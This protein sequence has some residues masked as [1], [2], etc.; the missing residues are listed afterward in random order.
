MNIKDYL[1]YSLFLGAIMTTFSC[2]DFLEEKS[3]ETDYNYYSTPEGFESAVVGSYQ[4]LRWL[5]TGEGGHRFELMGTDMYMRG[6]DGSQ[7]ACYGAYLAG[8]MSPSNGT[9]SDLWNNNYNGIA[10]VNTALEAV[11]SVQGIDESILKHRRGELLFLRAYYYY[12]LVI[13]YGDIPL[14]L[15][16][17]NSPKTDYVRVPQKEIWA[18]II[19]DATEAWNLLSWADAEG[20]VQGDYGRIG[21]GAAGHL[22]T[23]AHLFRYGQKYTSNQS[24]SHMNEDRGTESDDLDK[25]IYYS[26]Q[27][28]NFG[29][30][31]GSGSNH[32]LE[33][34]FWNLWGWDDKLGL[35]KEYAGPEVVFSI[36][37]ST[38]QFYNNQTATSTSGGNQI[39][40][41]CSAQFEAYPL[42]T[43]G[44]GDSW[45]NS[46]GLTRDYLTGRPWKRYAPTPYL[47]QDN[48]VY[49][50]QAYTCH[51]PGKLIDSRLYKAHV[52]TYYANVD[53]D[54]PWKSYSNAAGSFDAG[55]LEGTQRFAKG[56]TAIVLS[57][58][59]LDN[60]FPNGTRAEK[61]ALARYQER[62]W[63]LPLNSMY[64]PDN[65]HTSEKD[66]LCFAYLTTNKFLDSRRNGIQ[67]GAGYRSFYRYRLGETYILL[68]EALAMKG[69]LENASKAI[70]IVRKR[71]AWKKG[72]KKYHHFYKY[73][74]GKLEDFT[75]STE[76]DMMINASF[77]S[78]M[79]EKEL[80]EFFLDEN[81]R[82]TTGEM[83]RFESL[84]RY[85]ADFFVERVKAHNPFAAPN[86]KPFHRFRPIPQSHID[87]LIPADPNP[88]NYGY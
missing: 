10:T 28:C 67:T 50:S 55:A 59:N 42:T 82:E 57:L 77:L 40:M 26:S 23:K 33:P 17:I 5:A 41:H 11:E 83:N 45:G 48:G 36:E 6:G 15:N 56:D 20:K 53:P 62:Y 3:F 75:K 9:I 71:A 70:N 88:Q 73:D 51:K 30:G 34:D 16:T 7:H 85:G 8:N 49:G 46:I 1:K 35:V 13:H 18:Q 39:H 80:I 58:E 64:L 78:N 54:V 60:R 31:A 14:T 66:G 69:D 27:V 44:E 21:K 37:F 29:S 65:A 72:E 52:W 19:K 38:D 87:N 12:M 74:G 68:A 24:D 25:A 4:K 47:Y 76:A 32:S 43:Y 61:L 81:G 84:V 22:L 79:S 2:T 86:I 63:Y